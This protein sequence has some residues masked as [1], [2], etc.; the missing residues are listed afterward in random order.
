MLQRS[1]RVR[2]P[3][4]VPTAEQAEWLDR[5]EKIA[6]VLLAHQDAA[7]LEREV[8]APVF[9]ALRDAGF[10]R[11]W[12]ARAYGGEQATL[13][14]GMWALEALARIDASAAWLVGVQGAFSRLSD[15]LPEHVARE[16]FAE[17]AGFTVGAVKPTGLAEPV[18]GGYLVRGQWSMASGAAFA[19]WLSCTALVSK[20]WEPVFG[21]DGPDILMAFQPSS[22]LQRHPDTW[23]SLGLRGTGSGDFSAEERFVPA[24]YG[25]RKHQM[26]HAPEQRLRAYDTPFFDWGPFTA[27]PVA[28]GIAQA[29]LDEFYDLAQSKIPASG[30]QSL[31]DSHVVQ[32]QIARAEIAVHSARLSM[33]DAAR[34]V[35]EAGTGSPEASA[36]LRLACSTV[37]EVATS[38]VGTVFTLAGVTSV[39]E[40][41]PLER[42]FRDV[43]AAVKHLVLAPDHFSTVGAYL[44]GGPLVMRR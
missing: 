26:A 43:N 36:L 34:Q 40:A 37:A 14:A 44:L 17:T 3:Q 31:A 39:Y 30:T 19:D 2:L 16:V 33:F 15:Y 42:Y 28:L 7:E 6:P 29:A 27:A 20:D 41:S 1:E 35:T 32:D 25:V 10:L 5:V 21:P 24:E 38:A 12:V 22:T 11:M 8:Q 13:E 23:H 9:E 18:E 4:P